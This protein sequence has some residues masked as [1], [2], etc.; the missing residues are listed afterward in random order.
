ML[1]F[2]FV[3]EICWDCIKVAHCVPTFL[4]T[5]QLIGIDYVTKSYAYLLN[6]LLCIFVQNYFYLAY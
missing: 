1:C 6:T 2:H 3:Y 5:V 4:C